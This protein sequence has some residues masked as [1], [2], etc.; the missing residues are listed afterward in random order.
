MA[1][2]LHRFEEAVKMGG[3]GSSG[4]VLASTLL[5]YLIE[6]GKFLFHK[7]SIRIAGQTNRSFST[8]T[9]ISRIGWGLGPMGFRLCPSAESW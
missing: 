3:V 8:L 7:S 2:H 6:N 4:D 5:T 9:G 1:R